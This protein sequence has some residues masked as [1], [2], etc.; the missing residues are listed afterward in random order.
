MSATTT[1]GSRLR[2]VECVYCGCIARMS[3]AAMA[4]SGVPFCGCGEGRMLVA[5]LE[6]AARVLPEEELYAHPDF[7]ELAALE[8]RRAV[9]EATKCG[10]RMHC[11]GCNAFIPAANHDCSCGFSNHIVAGGRNAGRWVSGASYLP[12]S[13][14]H[15]EMPF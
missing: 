6:D 9:R 10:S 1:K 12:G 15:G 4:R 5:D 3:R 7:R 2:K 8:E 11:G 13:R 14:P